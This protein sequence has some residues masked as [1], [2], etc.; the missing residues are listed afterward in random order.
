MKRLRLLLTIV[1]L[2]ILVVATLLWWN[3]PGRVDMAA[4]APADSVV[5]LEFNSLTD[6]ARAIEENNIWKAL[7]TVVG[8]DPKLLNAWSL[9]AAR[10]GF[11]PAPSVVLTRAQFALVMVGLNS[12][13]EG[14][15]LRIRPEVALIVE[16]HT[17]NWRIKSLA[18]TTIKQLAV[19]A[20]G[21]S[22]CLERVAPDVHY[23]E[24]SSTLSDRKLVG[25]INGSVVIVGNALRA[26]ENSLEV[27]RGMRP[28]LLT[29]PDLQRLRQNMH[30]DSA[31]SFGYISSANVAKIFSFAAPLLMGQAPGD[32]ELEQVL[33]TSA[34]KIL[35]A[36]AWTSRSQSSGIEDQYLFSLEPE[37]RTRLEPAFKAT[38]TAD[39]FWQFVPQAVE[40][41]S[42][43]NQQNPSD[44]WAAIN[45]VVSYKLDAVSAVMFA[46]LLRASLTVYGIEKAN[47]VLPLLRSPI[48][49]MRARADAASS[50]LVARTDDTLQLQQALRNQFGGQIQILEDIKNDPKSDSEFVA[51]LVPG[52]VAIGKTASVKIWLEEIRGQNDR[53]STANDFKALQSRSGEAITTYSN[54]DARV[55]NFV[56]TFASFRGT[57]LSPKQINDLKTATEHSY[58][59]ISETS[60]YSNGLERKTRSSFGQFSTLLSLVQADSFSN[61]QP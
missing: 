55:N 56:S 47:E 50:V 46:S 52:H 8:T 16:T 38:E 21:Q 14:D 43:Y 60:L 40:T 15:T 45:G 10:A 13:E 26:V 9:G 2:L 28:S 32:R 12:I 37:V 20:Y 41:L 58:F 5:Y 22:S 18:V 51:V 6:L 23:V 57:A 29:D 44:A 59:S 36:I 11:A 31:L 53:S 1:V 39:D 61:S 19:H 25:A 35:R 54:D 27:R 33:A 3:R 34:Q 30:S 48:A 42:I 4:Y 24:C 17:S 49:T 7:A